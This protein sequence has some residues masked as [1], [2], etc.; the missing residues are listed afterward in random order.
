MLRRTASHTPKRPQQTIH[1]TT[2]LF[3]EQNAQESPKTSK[4][5]SKQTLIFP[6]SKPSKQQEVQESQNQH[7]Y[8]RKHRD[9]CDDHAW[10]STTRLQHFVVL[11]RH[12]PT[13]LKSKLPLARTFMCLHSPS[14]PHSEIA[15]TCSPQRPRS[16]NKGLCHNAYSSALRQSTANLHVSAVR[17]N[18]SSPRQS[19]IHGPVK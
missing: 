19:W 9:R 2:K 7:T 3:Q 4:Y 17:A 1:H 5:P 16:R 6:S 15:S 8:S 10:V 14:A 12:T 13:L 11:S 18:Y